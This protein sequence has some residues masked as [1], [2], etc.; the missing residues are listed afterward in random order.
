[1]TIKDNGKVIA[2][3]FVGSLSGNADTAS[4]WKTARTI[5]LTGSVTGSV[6]INGSGDVSLVTTTNHTHSYLPIS[7]GTMTGNIILK[8]GTSADMTYEGNV[9]PY[10]RFD[11]SDSTQNVSLIF[12]DYDTYRSPA[13]IKLIGN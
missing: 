8:G 10:I 11:N 7:G 5:T 2:N 12:T 13:G 4:K 1:M 9:H 6:S 3:T